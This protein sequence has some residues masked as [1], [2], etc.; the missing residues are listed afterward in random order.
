MGM[1][2][3]V[4]CNDESQLLGSLGKIGISSEC[5]PAGQGLYGLSIPAKVVESMGEEHLWSS[6]SIYE[7]YELW[8]GN[9]RLPVLKKK[10]NPAGSFGN[11]GH[12]TSHSSGAA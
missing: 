9:W 7:V 6:L 12:L 2:L 4:R 10:Q 8:S 1:Q 3:L 5:F 11:A